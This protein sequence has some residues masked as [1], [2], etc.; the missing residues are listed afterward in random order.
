MIDCNIYILT[1]SSNDTVKV[2]ITTK[3][4]DVRL[5]SINKEAIEYKF[6]LHHYRTTPIKQARHIEAVLHGVMENLGGCWIDDSF[7][8][9]TECARFKVETGLVANLLKHKMDELV[10]QPFDTDYTETD[11]VGKFFR[12]PCQLLS[13]KYVLNKSSNSKHTLDLVH[14]IVLVYLK[15]NPASQ[16][17]DCADC[18]G[19]SR[20]SV[21]RAISALSK[22]GLLTVNKERGVSGA[23]YNSYSVVDETGGDLVFYK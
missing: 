19:I 4:P 20:R 1:D 15:Q 3:H 18:L 14:K 22:A 23:M 21:I 5:A 13:C 10:V 9:S 2:G 16:Q 7:S 6:K 11:G 8:G 12:I 17:A